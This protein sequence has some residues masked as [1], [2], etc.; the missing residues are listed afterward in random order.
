MYL[1]GKIPIMIF[2]ADLTYVDGTI[3]HLGIFAG[4]FIYYI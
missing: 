4:I 1:D 3:T 2:G